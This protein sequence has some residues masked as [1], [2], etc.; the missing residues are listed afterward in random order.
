[1]KALAFDLGGRVE[2]AW[3]MRERRFLV[4]SGEGA[5]EF[6]ASRYRQHY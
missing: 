1:M 4:H 3:G 2:D 6:D 5:G